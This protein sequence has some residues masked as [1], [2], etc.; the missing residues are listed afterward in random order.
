M[1]S[2]STSIAAGHRDSLRQGSMTRPADIQ[3]PPLT[4]VSGK[5]SGLH[6]LRSIKL[7]RILQEWRPFSFSIFCSA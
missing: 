7:Y 1:H 2:L 5:R 3:A 6:G 4:G